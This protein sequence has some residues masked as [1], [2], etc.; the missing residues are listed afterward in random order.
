MAAGKRSGHTPG[1]AVH[2]CIKPIGLEIKIIQ[3][4]HL[5]GEPEVLCGGL[6]PLPQ[7]GLATSGR[8]LS[9]SK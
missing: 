4:N 7:G 3:R 1:V 2:G 8:A 9:P 6:N 5:Y